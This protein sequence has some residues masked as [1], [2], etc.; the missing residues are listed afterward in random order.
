MAVGQS[1]GQLRDA[2]QGFIDAKER[3]LQQT[4]QLGQRVLEQ[5]VELEAR[6][7]QLREV[8]AEAGDDEDVDPETETMF[9]ELADAM[10]GWDTDNVK[11]SDAFS[12]KVRV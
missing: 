10:H 2:L 6:I 7:E 4:G 3:Q 12:N 5:Q 1:A 9:T 8:A 11:L